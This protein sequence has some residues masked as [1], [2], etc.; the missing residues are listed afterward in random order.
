MERCVSVRCYD[1][2]T[3]GYR[4]GIDFFACLVESIEFFIKC[5]DKTLGCVRIAASDQ[6]C[7][8][9]TAEPACNSGIANT[10]REVT[11]NQGDGKVTLVVS[12]T[13]IHNL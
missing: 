4:N 1:T 12:K 9:I 13:I 5:F 11:C 6:T 7:K 3:A 8:F 2:K 10:F